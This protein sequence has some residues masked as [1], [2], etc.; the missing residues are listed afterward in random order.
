MTYHWPITGERLLNECDRGPEIALHHPEMKLLRSQTRDDK[1]ISDSVPE[2][3]P[4]RS[5]SQVAALRTFA[6]QPSMIVA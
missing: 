1:M 6:R 5:R 4:S 2:P 3:D